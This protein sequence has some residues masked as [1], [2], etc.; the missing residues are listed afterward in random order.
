[1]NTHDG[2]A[3]SPPAPIGEDQYREYLAALLAGERATCTRTVEALLAG[4]CPL[5]TLY[6]DLFQRS[7]YEVGCLWEGNKISVATEHL[8]TAITEN[9]MVLG[10]PQVFASPRVGH[11]AIVTCCVDEYHQLGAKMV[12]DLLELNGWDTLFLGA[13][14][15]ETAVCAMAAERR[16]DLVCLSVSLSINLPRV[17]TTIAAIRQQQP[18]LT[19]LVGGQ[20]LRHATGSTIPD[21]PQT[22]IMES[23]DDLERFVQAYR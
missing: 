2:S 8:A 6:V 15:P 21:H 7:L 23:L 13:S 16:P 18:S 10:Y 9:L 14:T 19:I 20:A 22:R 3:S 5:K 4:G 17:T 1:M 11:R 12:A